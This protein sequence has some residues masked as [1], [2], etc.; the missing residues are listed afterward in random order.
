[1]ALLYAGTTARK[2]VSTTMKPVL[3]NLQDHVSLNL[4]KY[5]RLN[6]EERAIF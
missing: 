3:L 5:L 2:P 4:K 1:M 6:S